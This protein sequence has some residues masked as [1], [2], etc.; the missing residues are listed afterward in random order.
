MK[1]L[2]ILTAL[3][4]VLQFTYAAKGLVVE[5]KYTSD[6]AIG[7][8]ISVTWY[9]TDDACKMQMTFSDGKVNT[10]SDFIADRKGNQLLMFN[11]GTPSGGQAKT[12]FAMPTNKIQPPKDMD[13]SGVKVTRTGETMQFGGVKCEKMVVST[14]LTETEMWVTVDVKY[15]FYQY[16]PFF[17]SNYDILGLSAEKIK[18]FPV[19]SITK[20]LQGKVIASYDL[21]SV[22]QTEIA[23]AEFTVPADYKKAQ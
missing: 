19:K 7:S 10:V 20:N 17:R 11:E 1:K 6:N 12:Y 4:A 23:D 14:T 15:P 3:L 8:T 13:V 5:Q 16:F 2:T 21:V 22:K 18:G 9:I